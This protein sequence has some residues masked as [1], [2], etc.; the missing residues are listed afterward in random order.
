[1]KRIDTHTQPIKRISVENIFVNWSYITNSIISNTPYQNVQD[2]CVRVYESVSSQLSKINYW[3]FSCVFP[4]YFHRL[5]CICTIFPLIFIITSRL[6]AFSCAHFFFS[7]LLR[8]SI[9]AL[10]RSLSNCILFAKYFSWSRVWCADIRVQ[11]F[12]G[13][14]KLT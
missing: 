10:R 8:M 1:M 13:K 7:L 2:V 6:A 11:W 4:F 3:R 12:R 14:D 5:Q 9:P